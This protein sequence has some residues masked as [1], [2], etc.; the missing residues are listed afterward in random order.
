M[1]RRPVRRLTRALAVFTLVAIA[2]PAL[3]AV[4]KEA[5]LQQK[6][7]KFGYSQGDAVDTIQ[8]YKVDGWNYLDDRHIMLYTGPSERYLIGLMIDCYNLST[9]ETI[10]FTSTVSQLTKFDKLVVKGGH[11][12]HQD[13]PITDIHKLNKVDK[14]AGA[15]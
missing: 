14:K 8:N 4:D 15:T 12:P 3:A 6:I 1:L 11:M 2:L 7:A 13:C 5:L 9:A 10:G